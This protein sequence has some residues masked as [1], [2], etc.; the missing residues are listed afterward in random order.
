MSTW[1]QKFPMQSGDVAAWLD[2][3][4]E[5]SF[6]VIAP[7]EMPSHLPTELLEKCDAVLVMRSG[8]YE[9][10]YIVGNLY[11]RDKGKI[12]QMPFGSVII[13]GSGSSGVLTHHGDWE[14][15]TFSGSD[16]APSYYKLSEEGSGI[17]TSSFATLGLPSKE[18][19]SITEVT[20]ESNVAAFEAVLEELRKCSEKG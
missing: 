6:R 7:D 15:R 4:P 16:T 9:K 11:R 20:P 14:G 13:S 12:D 1:F 18:S 8:S 10:E 2:L 3:A 5:N 19:G 17:Y